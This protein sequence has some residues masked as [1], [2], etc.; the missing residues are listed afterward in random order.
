ME[1][2]F[3]LFRALRR[4]FAGHGWTV[5]AMVVLGILASFAEGIGVT[6]FIPFIARMGESSI[7]EESSTHS[8]TSQLDRLFAAIPTEKRLLIICLGIFGAVAAKVLLT[9]LHGILLTN[10]DWKVGTKV[11]SKLVNQLFFIDFREFER[12]DSGDV[13]NIL[14]EESWNATNVLSALINFTI[15]ASTLAVYLTILFLISPKLTVIAMVAMAGTSWIARLVTR[16]VRRIGQNLTRDNGALAMRMLE[17]VQGNKL[18]R[19]FGRER[20]EKARFDTAAGR[21]GKWCLKLGYIEGLVPPIY[22]LCGAA[23]LVFML[24]SGAHTTGHMGTTLVYIFALY[25]I[26]PKIAA[27]EGVRVSLNAHA[28]SIQVV[29]S[30]L[31]LDN[32]TSLLLIGRS[33]QGLVREIRFEQVC[34]R[35][36]PEN[37]FALSDVSFSFPAG[38]TT[39]LVGPSGAGKSTVI[40]LLLGLY[41][42]EKGEIR[43]DGT[44]LRDFSM[45]AWRERIA[46][47]SQDLYVFNA[48]I[49]ENIAYGK[50]DA[51]ETDIIAAAEQ[52]NAHQ[53]IMNLPEGYST[54]VG[55]RGFRLS[56]GQ[57]QRLA[58][59][60]AIVR[61][62]EILV[63]DEATNALDAIKEQVIQEALQH[64]GRSRTVIVIAHR[65]C[66]VEQADHVVVLEEGRLQE[67]GDLETLLKANGL[68]S[69]LYELQFQTHRGPRLTAVTS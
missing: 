20:F 17:A 64:F 11:R 43:V 12:R 46:V 67:E 18:I 66:T 15:T 40:K 33:F 24:L 4:L 49:R 7:R 23:L 62:P 36:G 1:T 3:R 13:I 32:K 27:L 51:T 6:L 60:R 14:A 28:S 10:L 37:K 26:Q 52:A 55:D 53:F 16:Q 47:V 30:L 41:E 2:E 44:P 65:L 54:M 56:G 35:Y 48:T 63:L 9:Y 68:F 29:T 58:L 8:F 42:V 21:V 59:A 38:K 22:E 25:R 57:L 34:F 39:A 19:M 69:Q 50:L 31:E 45:T 61:N 5:A